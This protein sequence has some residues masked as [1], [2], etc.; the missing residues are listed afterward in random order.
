MH[1]KSLFF[2]QTSQ[3]EMIKNM[4]FD[5][6]YHEHI[7]FFNIKSMFELTK[8]AGLELVDVYKEKI[9]GSSYIFLIKKR[10]TNI[11]KIKKYIKKERYLS[12]KLYK[13]WSLNCKN[14]IKD[15][16]HQIKTQ[17]KSSFKVIGYGAAA[18]GNT[19]INFG[20]L[21][22]DF[23]IDD[24][25]LKQKKYSPGKKIPIKNI[26]SLSK[27]SVKKKITFVPLAWN[28]YKEIRYKIKRKRKAPKDVFIKYFPKVTL[29]N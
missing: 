17:N 24:N 16:K 3:A 7:N 4:E 19:L 12:I 10:K 14:L 6:V 18:K 21:N 15:L 22:L 5:T 1:E 11:N 8:R 13:K 27:I 26:N 20:N 2:I 28:F 29:S 23:I 25:P 9:F